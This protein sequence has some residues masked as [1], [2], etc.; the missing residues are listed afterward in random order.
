M[1][2]LDTCSPNYAD[3][4]AKARAEFL[5]SCPAKEEPQE[6]QGEQTKRFTFYSAADII[7]TPQQTDAIKGVAQSYGVITIYGPSGSGKSF[8]SVHMANC[9]GYGSCPRGCQ[10]PA[11]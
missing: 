7:N 8:L 4:I 1:T 2:S 11:C 6:Q 9:L 5:A 3:A 10:H